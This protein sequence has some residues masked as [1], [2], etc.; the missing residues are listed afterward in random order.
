[1]Y[2][3]LTKLIFFKVS[4]F[5]LVEYIPSKI[6][7]LKL[8]NQCCSSIERLGPEC[9]GHKVSSLT[10]GIKSLKKRLLAASVW[11]SGPSTFLPPYENTVLFTSGGCSPYQ[12]TQSAGA[13]ILDFPAS[14]PV[15]NTFLLFIKNLTKYLALGILLKQYHG[16]KLVTRIYKEHT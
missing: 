15:R 1:M 9:L 10:N 14:K 16:T 6:L 5:K 11:L 13:F 8:N 3:Q 4:E 7:V 2:L 12:T